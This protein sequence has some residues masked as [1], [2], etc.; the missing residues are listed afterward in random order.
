[1]YSLTLDLGIATT[2][3]ERLISKPIYKSQVNNRKR[4]AK[5]FARSLLILCPKLS[6]SNLPQFEITFDRVECVVS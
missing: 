5:L 6:L 4:I 1:M 2:K 3:D